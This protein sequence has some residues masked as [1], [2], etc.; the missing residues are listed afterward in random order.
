MMNYNKNII[1]NNKCNKLY[2]FFFSLQE[3]ENKGFKNILLHCYPE[4]VNYF[5]RVNALLKTL[6]MHSVNTNKI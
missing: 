2:F 1:T 6:F 5:D 4:L 3:K